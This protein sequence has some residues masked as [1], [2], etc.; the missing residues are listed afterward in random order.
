VKLVQ[1]PGV[2]R[3]T[4]GG[5]AAPR[6]D[7]ELRLE[8]TPIV[9][10]QNNKAMDGRRPFPPFSVFFLNENEKT[11]VATEAFRPGMILQVFLDSKDHW[12]QMISSKKPF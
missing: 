5:W 3:S 11:M 8:S 9:L 1:L 10:S 12:I 4:T 7:G 2:T 6:K